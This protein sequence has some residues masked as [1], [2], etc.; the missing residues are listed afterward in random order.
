MPG[1]LFG[2]DASF[3]IARLSLSGE[4]FIVSKMEED[5][6]WKQVDGIKNG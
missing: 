2:M 6:R 5:R 3:G 4:S 1:F